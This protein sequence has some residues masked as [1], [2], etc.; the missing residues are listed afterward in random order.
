[1]IDFKKLCLSIKVALRG[2]KTA[3]FEEQSFK[4][5]FAIGIF[6]VFLMFYFPLS[7]LEKAI[8]VLTII[9]V[10]SLE[11]INS[12]IERILDFLEPN[13]NSKIRKIKDLSAAAVLLVCFGAVIIG[14]F[15]F[16]T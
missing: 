8:L 2:L 3:I 16:W 13:H 11:L 7:G 4:I 14:L 10:L 6:V 12:Q 5:Q 1:M 15:I 9:L